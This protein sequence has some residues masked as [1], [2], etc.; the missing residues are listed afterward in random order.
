[1]VVVVVSS[2]LLD[3]VLPKSLANEQVDRRET[4]VSTGV[5]SPG[6]DQL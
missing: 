4:R 6:K 2:K 5:R 3:F 1:M